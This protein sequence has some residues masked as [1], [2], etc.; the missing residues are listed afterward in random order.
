MMIHAQSDIDIKYKQTRPQPIKHKQIH[1]FNGKERALR[2]KQDESCDKR[3][4]AQNVAT[5]HKTHLIHSQTNSTGNLLT[6]SN[7]SG[8]IKTLVF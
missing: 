6:G 8:C 4:D 3:Q 1:K 7:I 2:P 5:K